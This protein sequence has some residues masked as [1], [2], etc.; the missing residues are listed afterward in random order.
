MIRFTKKLLL[1]IPDFWS[2]VEYMPMIC[3]VEMMHNGLYCLLYTD[4]LNAKV[5]TRTSSNSETLHNLKIHYIKY[6]E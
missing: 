5:L 1:R 3:T 4:S 2:L 6:M